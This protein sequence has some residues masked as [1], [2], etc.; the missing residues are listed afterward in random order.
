[1][2][3]R[4]CPQPP[5]KALPY[6]TAGCPFAVIPVRLRHCKQIT[7]EICLSKLDSDCVVI[8]RRSPLRLLLPPCRIQIYPAHLSEVIYLQ[9]LTGVLRGAILCLLLMMGTAMKNPG[10]QDT[11]R[12]RMSGGHPFGTE[13]S[14]AQ[15]SDQKQRGMRSVPGPGC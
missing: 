5:K 2:T 8:S 1:M 14:G 15:N 7:S 3:V 9:C 10:G 12:C 6:D 13:R 4:N 11:K